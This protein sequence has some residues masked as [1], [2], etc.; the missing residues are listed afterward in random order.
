M[1]RYCILQVICPE[2][3]VN[4]CMVYDTVYKL[5]TYLLTDQDG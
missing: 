2:T 5:L 3:N 4:V 1:S